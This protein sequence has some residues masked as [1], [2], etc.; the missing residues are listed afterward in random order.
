MGLELDK[1]FEKV[2]E[3]LVQQ[4]KAVAEAEKDQA[5]PRPWMNFADDP[6]EQQASEKKEEELHDVFSRDKVNE[7]YVKARQDEEAKSRDTGLRKMTGDFLGACER[8]KRMQWRGRIRMM[9][10]TAARAI[11]FGDDA[12][13]LRRSTVDFLERIVMK[14]REL[15]KSGSGN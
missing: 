12:G 8:D 6:L 11:G 3:Y 9:A 5:E 15:E 10:H 13:P 4:E 7:A 14:S 1:T 2:V